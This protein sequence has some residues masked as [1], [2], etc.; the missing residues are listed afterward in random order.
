[1]IEFSAGYYFLIIF[2]CKQQ[3]NLENKKIIIKQN[4]KIVIKQQ[5]N[6]K[7]GMQKL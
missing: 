1:M 6:A 3:T 7:I 2:V 4:K 5:K